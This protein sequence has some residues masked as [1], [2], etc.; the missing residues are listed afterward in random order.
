[1][2]VNTN[3]KTKKSMEKMSRL[4]FIFEVVNVRLDLLQKTLTPIHATMI[5]DDMKDIIKLL[6]DNKR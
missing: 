5:I 4:D 6:G 1:M 3:I 2:L